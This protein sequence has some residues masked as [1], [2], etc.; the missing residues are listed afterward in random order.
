VTIGDVTVIEGS[1]GTTSAV[2]TILASP[3]PKPC[4]GL[5]VSWATAPGTAGAPADYSTSSG[6]VS[7]T[8]SAPSRTVTVPVVGDTA[9]EADETFVVNLSNLVGSPGTI[10][11][12]QGVV[13]ITD[14]DPLPVLS[15]NDVGVTE[16][17]AGTTTA[18]FSISLSAASG[19]PVTVSW[20]TTAGTATAGTDYVAAS[21]SRT[22]AAGSTTATVGITVN[23][24]TL[25]E[26]D[27]TF[28]IGLSGPVNATIGDG[29]GVAT[30]TDDDL[31]PVLSVNDVGV[32]EGDAG[33]TTATFSISLSAASGQDVGVSWATTVGTATAGTDYVAGSGSRTISAGSTTATV[34]ITVNGDTL[35]EEDE[36]FGIA[37]SGPA[38]A[39]IGDGSGVATI[40][41]DDAVPVLSVSDVAVT[42][43]NAGTTTMGFVVT[44]SAASGRTITVGWA[45]SD[46]DA[47]S[48]AD[49]VA[50]SGTFTFAPGET[51]KTASVTVNGDVIAELDEVLLVS[52]S[53][54]VNATI[55]VA[56]AEGTI[57]DD[58]LLPVIDVDAPSTVEG[59]GG[60]TGL[61][62]TLSLS[63]P[64]ALP[65]TVDWSTAPGTATAGTDYLSASG[66]VTFAAL[67]T[68]ETVVI[69]VN[70][71]A[72][73][74]HGETV[75]LDLTNSTNA[76]IGRAR[77]LGTITNDDAPPDLSVADGSVVEGNAGTKILTFTVS[78]AG[79]SEVAGSVDHATSDST[80]TAGS[81]YV[82][83]SATLT[84]P[85]GS[86]SRTIDVTVKGDA[87]YEANEFF[88]LTLSGPT[89]ATIG[90]GSGRGT[91]A[92]DDPAPTSITLSVRST[93]RNVSAKGT[94]EPTK[95][96]HRVT[97]TL[98]KKQAGRFVKVAATTVKVKGVK[99]RDADGR[100]DG[101]YAASFA[102]P[103]AGDTYK[104]VARFKGT[105]TYAPCSRSK[106]LSLGAL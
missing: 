49:Y 11:D 75:A 86:S 35:D 103:A 15:V 94:L 93:D 28:G 70:G 56:Q 100:K 42:E 51:S 62:F 98:F 104:I 74:E 24:D 8:K 54:P 91:I 31:L 16:G 53:G 65:V 43:G 13:T 97:V 19:R 12:A 105:S 37:L 96:G 5:Q 60:A 50:A 36:T 1:S 92:N 9:D 83:A 61:T 4:C 2:F 66:T 58:E 38:N 84:I 41:D 18:T 69:T 76:P 89:D 45:T 101:S 10:A 26:N 33:T 57:V 64:S 23:G 85:A 46:D 63:N 81:D 82:A 29:S 47:V 25:E 40:T 30:I 88:L 68:S 73:Y 102:R 3:F 78:L 72:V 22:I 80:A 77:S 32:T 106:R 67:D 27:E 90:D 20:A 87:A 21:G 7:L 71:D 55:G 52:L 6:T 17:D 14:D 44:L 48:P 79:A 99:D 95:V 34:G 59:G 39:T